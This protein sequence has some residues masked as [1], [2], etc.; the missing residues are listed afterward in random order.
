MEE[1]ISI[2]AEKVN[3]EMLEHAKNFTRNIVEQMGM[4]RAMEISEGGIK[5]QVFERKSEI[6]GKPLSILL[7]GIGKILESFAFY[8]HYDV[9]M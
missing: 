6:N 8:N 3:E 7:N 5:T 1:E 9:M 4:G 2:R